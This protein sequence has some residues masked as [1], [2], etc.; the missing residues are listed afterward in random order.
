[1]SCRCYS[2]RLN[3]AAPK[4]AA[5]G[6]GRSTPEH[7]GRRGQGE[8]DVGMRKRYLLVMWTTVAVAHGPWRP[9]L[10]TLKLVVVGSDCRTPELVGRQDRGEGTACL[11]REGRAGECFLSS[12][13]ERNEKVIA[14]D[15]SRLS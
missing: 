1:M 14:E 10:V 12:K 4:L 13:E 2:W 9:D 6:F 15:G 3:L 8:G 7:M 5:A 11:P